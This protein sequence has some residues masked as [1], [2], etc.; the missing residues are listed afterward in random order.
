MANQHLD[1]KCPHCGLEYTAFIPEYRYFS[2]C[3]GCRSTH[4]LYKH[5]KNVE[6]I[7]KVKIVITGN[8]S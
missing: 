2:D 1:L 8:T 6:Y 4:F 3:P 5:A 7:K